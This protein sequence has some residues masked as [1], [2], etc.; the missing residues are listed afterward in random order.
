MGL[1]ALA[2]NQWDAEGRSWALDVGRAMEGAIVGAL[3][4]LR[5]L[6]NTA[7]ALTVDS[8]GSAVESWAEEYDRL[9][10]GLGAPS[11]ASAFTPALVEGLPA[12]TALLAWTAIP[13]TAARRGA[14]PRTVSALELL[15]RT[16]DGATERAQ[17]ERLRAYLPRVLPGLQQRWGAW[18]S[19]AT[20]APVEP[21]PPSPPQSGGGWVLALVLAL[22]Y[23]AVKRGRR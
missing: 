17:G 18:V 16:C 3:L 7:T 15:A 1:V 13:R 19:T 8:P 21:R 2:W 22:G 14:S 9:A 20:L 6:H 10:V 5:E 4:P 23:V 12:G 11:V